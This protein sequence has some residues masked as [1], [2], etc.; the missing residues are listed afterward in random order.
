[1]GKELKALE[2]ETLAGT[3]DGRNTANTASTKAARGKAPL[4]AEAVLL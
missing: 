4:R 2:E 3:G 1:M